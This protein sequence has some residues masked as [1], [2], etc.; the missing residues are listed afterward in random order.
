MSRLAFC[1]LYVIVTAVAPPLREVP[2]PVL[3]LL[4]PA[5]QEQLRSLRAETEATLAEPDLAPAARSGAY[6]MLGQYYYLYD[7]VEAAEAC[8]LNARALDPKDFRWPY[9]LG[10]LYDREGRLEEAA[11]N[12]EAAAALR[13]EDLATLLRLGEI[14]LKEGD[15]EAA[16][17]RFAAALALDPQSAAAHYG[18]GRVA[19]AQGRYAE[20]ISLFEATLAL[21]PE[22]SVVHHQLGLAYRERGDLER[23]RAHLTQ[24]RQEQVRFPDPLVLG[25]NTLLKGADVHSKAGHEATRR[26]DLETALERYRKAAEIDP[27]DALHQYNLGRALIQAGQQEKG[28]A[29]FRRALEIDPDYR[30]AHFNLATALA[31]EER[32]EEAGQH[33]ARAFEI[34]PRDHLAHFEWAIALS[35]TGQP[36]A[37][38]AELEQ[39]LAVPSSNLGTALTPAQRAQAHTLLGSLY[40]TAGKVEA[41]IGQYQAALKLDPSLR[42]VRRDLAGLLGRSQRFMAAAAVYNELIAADPTAVEDHFGR[43]MA[44]LLGGNYTAARDALRASLEALPGNVPLGHALARLLATCPDAT[45]RDG[46]RALALAEAAFNAEP[47]LDHAETVAMAHA[48]RADFITAVSW[49]R[50]VVVERERLGNAALLERARRRLERYDNGQPCRAPWADG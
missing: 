20:S 28:V 37:A 15:L 30:D 9:Y 25:L 12:L 22:A 23:A 7:L 36:T 31:A 19:F 10:A 35:K 8:F 39:L 45:V 5:D 3:D 21:Q 47:T 17:D 29:R 4:E 42:P 1:L 27:H 18:R 33:F 11:A 34:D 48:E 38:L 46:D 16:D 6:G 49:Q 14:R 2:K 43:G 41:A 24:N 50:R 44:L 40:V 32:F 13:P 26:G